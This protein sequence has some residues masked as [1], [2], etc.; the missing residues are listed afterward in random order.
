MF[1]FIVLGKHRSWNYPSKTLLVIR[2]NL[3]VIRK[4]LLVIRKNLLVIR[5]T[6][7]TMSEN[8]NLRKSL[9]S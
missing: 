1:L 2:K 4:N 7:F 8:K 3:L 6:F 9:S 5:K